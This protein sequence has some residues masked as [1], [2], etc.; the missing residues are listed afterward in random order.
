MKTALFAIGFA[1]AIATPAF[2]GE[3]PLLHAQIA[4]AV[5]NRFDNG[6]YTAKV[7]SNEGEKLHKEGKHADSVKK[8][9]EAAKAAGITLKRK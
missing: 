5:G 9:E 1:A 4:S 6:A 7:L 3:C 8:Y 2:A